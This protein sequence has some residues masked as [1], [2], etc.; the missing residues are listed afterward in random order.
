[1]NV[2]LSALNPMTD[3]SHLPM[4]PGAC[5]WVSVSG[6][7]SVSSHG[8]AALGTGHGEGS[9]VLTSFRAE[10]QEVLC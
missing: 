3:R 6:V 10:A 8:L 2:I 9:L 1:M 5:C 4:H 7:G